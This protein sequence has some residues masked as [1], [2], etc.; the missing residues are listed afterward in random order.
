MRFFFA[1]VRGFE[2]PRRVFFRTGR[3]CP[4]S[5]ARVRR[6]A[7]THSAS[8][9]A[10]VLTGASSWFCFCSCRY[11]GGAGQR[12]ATIWD[13]KNCRSV[14]SPNYRCEKP[15]RWET[16]CGARTKTLSHL[17]A[18]KNNPRS[19]KLGKTKHCTALSK[20][21]GHWETNSALGAR[22]K[23]HRIG[24]NN[25]AKQNRFRSNLSRKQ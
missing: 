6:D 20:K 15:W 2:F 23:P 11:C 18:P 24:E 8:P 17:H 1:D 9:G 13:R 25:H 22:V 12:K 5:P 4:W 7:L 3:F 16:N 10:Q 21:C 14:C 19:F